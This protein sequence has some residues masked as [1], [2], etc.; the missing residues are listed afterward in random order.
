M[1]GKKASAL[2]R[3]TP[4]YGSSVGLCLEHGHYNWCINAC[5]HFFKKMLLQ[6]AVGSA[7]SSFL[8]LTGSFRLASKQLVC[9]FKLG[10]TQ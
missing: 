10:Y 9:F 5:Q 2:G 4:F 1:Q 8:V 7:G 6:R 3:P